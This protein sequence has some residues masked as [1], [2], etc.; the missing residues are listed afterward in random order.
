MDNTITVID[1]HNKSQQHKTIQMW[2]RDADSRPDGVELA[3]EAAKEN[4]GKMWFAKVSTDQILKRVR[5]F[6]QQGQQPKKQMKW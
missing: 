5:T 4:N 6:E 2:L 3:A 1:A